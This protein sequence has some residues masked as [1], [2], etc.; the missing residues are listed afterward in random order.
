MTDLRLGD[1]KEMIKDIPDK[2]IDLVVTDPPYL[3]IKG[4]CKSKRLNV[5]C[6]DAH[7]DVVDKMSDFGQEQ[8]NEFLDAV[9]PKMKQV[10]MYVFCSKL[11]IPHYLNWA[12]KN[13][14]QYDLLFW[15]KNTNRMISTKFYAS[16]VEYIVRIYGSGCS[17]KSILD[18]S[19]KARSEMYQ[20]IFCYDTPKNKEH[21]AQKPVEMLER[22]ILLSSNKGDKVLD[23]FMGSGSTALACVRTLRNFI[24]IEIDEKAYNTARKRLEEELQ[25]NFL[26]FFLNAESLEL[27]DDDEVCSEL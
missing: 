27:K 25:H 1:Y 5:G 4:G 3:H 14:L 20:K 8:I 22:L 7:S 10:N 18:E 23:C 9:K 26:G 17:L 15:Y 6:R 16:N 13:K 11:Q 2:S 12:I 24:G 19:G 21:E